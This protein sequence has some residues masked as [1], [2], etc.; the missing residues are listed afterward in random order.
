MKKMIA[1]LTATLSA[2]VMCAL[3]MANAVTSNAAT[4]NDRV[5]TFRIY[6]EVKAGSLPLY[7]VEVDRNFRNEYKNDIA[8]RKAKELLPGEFT[9]THP[10]R[11]RYCSIAETDYL[12][13]FVGPY[14]TETYDCLVETTADDFHSEGYTTEVYGSRKPRNG[15]AVYN[16]ANVY[17]EE[18]VLVGD[19]NHDGKVETCDGS[20]ILQY[21]ANPSKY[22]SID[23]KAADVDGDGQ[24][25]AYD[26]T[27][28]SKFV[29][30][31]INSLGDV[32][33]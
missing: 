26:A 8:L 3:P 11:N 24:V 23:K 5:Q 2:A 7:F 14:S 28:I 10:S 20:F 12:A 19:S 6:S 30:R 33:A 27:L 31:E 22:S 29:N 25:T 4:F 17:S 15:L 18:V 1:K 13:Y 32:Q 9:Y 16:M 21:L